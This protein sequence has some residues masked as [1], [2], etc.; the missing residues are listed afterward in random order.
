VSEKRDDTMNAADWQAERFE[1]H[2]GRLRA[3]AYRMLGSPSDAGDA[4]QE[5]WLRFN[6]SDTSAVD[7]LGAWL[8][9]VVSRVCLN[10]LE[11]RRSRP[12]PAFDPDLPEPPAEPDESDPEHEALLAD[13]VGLAMLVVLDTLAPAERVAFVLHDVFAIPFDEIAPIVERSVPA[14]RQLASRARARVRRQERNGESDRIR[15]AELVDAFLGAARQGDFNALIAVLDPDV[16]LRADEHAVELGAEAE[17]R[18]AEPVAAWSR[19]ARGARPALLAGAP[20]AAW[21]PDGS[22]RVV[23]EFTV[24]GGHIAAIELIADPERLA[25]LDLTVLDASWG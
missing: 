10:M 5:A 16:V 11:A 20:A 7:N 12:Q 4:V 19:R 3:I 1:E 17:T 8:T 2:R 21:L 13:S 18:G 25:E 9:T 22:L 6:R 15:Q 23:Y 24:R 14:T